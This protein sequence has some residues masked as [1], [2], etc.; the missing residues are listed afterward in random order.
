MLDVALSSSANV[1]TNLGK[2][3]LARGRDDVASKNFKFSLA[4]DALNSEAHHAIGVPYERLGQKDL[5]AAHLK[6]SVAMRSSN[7]SAQTDYGNFLC[8]QGLYA[9]ADDHFRTASLIPLVQA[10]LV[11]M[12]NEGICAHLAGRYQAEPGNR[13]TTFRQGLS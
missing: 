1:Y 12:T 3:Y 8:A 13:K 6:R 10:S 2:Q 5:A 7:A 4:T 9:E 11:A